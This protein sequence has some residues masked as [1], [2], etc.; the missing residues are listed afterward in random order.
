MLPISPV[1]VDFKPERSFNNWRCCFGCK[2]WKI[3][4]V[5]EE[6]Q[7]SPIS[8]QIIET[9]TRTYEKYR[10]S[11]SPEQSILPSAP[12]F[13]MMESEMPPHLR[14]SSIAAFKEIKEP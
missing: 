9:V 2:C 6:K 11:S 8:M 13:P 5:Q 10:H 14:S 12:V 4:S 7:D 1:Q 3:T